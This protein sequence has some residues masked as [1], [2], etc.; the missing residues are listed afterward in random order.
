MSPQTTSILVAAICAVTC[1]GFWVWLVA[2]PVARS[3]EGALQRTIAVVLSGYTLLVGVMIGTGVGLLVA[4]Q[5]D[6]IA[7]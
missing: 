6:R 2:V 7:Q 5:W 4:Y 3:F 1:I